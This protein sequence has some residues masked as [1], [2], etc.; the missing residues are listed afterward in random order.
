[1][2]EIS[3]VLP[4]YNGG[5]FLQDSILSICDQTFTNW[6]L[7][8]VDDA[9]T[10]DSPSIISQFIKRDSRIRCIRNKENQKLPRSLNIGFY[11]AVGKY[12]TW[13]SDDNIYKKNAFFEMKKYLENHSEYPMVRA[14]LEFIDEEGGVRGDYGDYNE[15]KMF[16]SNCVGACFLYRREVLSAIG[17][18]DEHLFLVEDYDY[19]LRIIDHYGGIGSLHKCLYQYRLHQGSLTAQ[20]EKERRIPVLQLQFKFLENILTRFRADKEYLSSLYYDFYELDIDMEKLQEK[21]RPFLEPFEMS[22]QW[23]ECRKTIIY[24]AGKFGIRAMNLLKKDTVAYFVDR[25]AELL[26]KELYGI[27]IISFHEMCDLKQQYNICIALPSDCM[28]E[29]IKQF[30]AARVYSFVTYGWLAY[31]SKAAKLEGNKV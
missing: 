3:V 26:G 8:I 13:T 11:N 16:F 23:M 15:N 6:E 29:V 27:K 18:Y 10:D 1:M 28:Y 19:W 5:E 2:P 9:S 7:I 31:R 17:G 4:V 21:M 25:N 24:G 14:G 20:M 12:L 22:D 30:R